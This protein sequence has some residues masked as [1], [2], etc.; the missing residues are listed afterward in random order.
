MDPDSHT[1]HARLRDGAIIVRYPDS[2]W[3]IIHP[4]PGSMYPG[5][6][7]KVGIAAYLA[8]R[9]GSPILGVPGGK[10][11]DRLVEKEQVTHEA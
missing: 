6:R 8:V 1:I 11:F 9:D 4:E 5:R 2:Q 3:W 10:V 7:V